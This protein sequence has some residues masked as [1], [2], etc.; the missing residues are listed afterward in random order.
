MPSWGMPFFDNCFS[1]RIAFPSIFKLTIYNLCLQFL[2][3]K[4]EAVNAHANQG[5]EAFPVKDVSQ[6]LKCVV[7]SKMYLFVFILCVLLCAAP[8]THGWCF[9]RTTEFLKKQHSCLKSCI[10]SFKYE[11][12]EEDAALK[13]L[14]EFLCFSFIWFAIYFR[15]LH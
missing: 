1:Y 9:V 6:L 5:V 11:F 15:I 10:V 13:Y 12:E 4:L 8:Q 2:S 3:M 7:E 14:N